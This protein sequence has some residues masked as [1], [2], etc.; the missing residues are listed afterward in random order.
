[1]ELDTTEAA[2]LRFYANNGGAR[3]LDDELLTPAMRA[4]V[5]GEVEP[6]AAEPALEHL[7][8]VGCGHG[9]HLAWA[10]ERGLG[11]DG[12]DIVPWL[13][14]KGRAALGAMAQ[15]PQRCNLHV[16]TAEELATVWAAQGLAARSA[17]TIVFF[18]FNCFGNVARPERVAEAVAATGARV[19]LSVLTPSP[20]STARRHEYYA[21]VGYTAL[22]QRETERGVLFTSAEGLWSFA[23]H[24]S[25][26]EHVLGV[27]G[28]TLARAVAMGPIAAGYLFCPRTRAP[29]REAP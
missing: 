4:Y 22:Q 27:V 10:R 24:L 11:Y 1:L 14:E 8:E 9:R 13:V 16:G 3:M 20:E 6:L 5:H 26:L 25:F 2:V 19:F 15:A 23:Y 29:P 28:Y 18:P 12:L 7:F 21:G 17:A